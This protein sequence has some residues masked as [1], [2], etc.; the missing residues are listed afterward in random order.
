MS[1]NA[2][3]ASAGAPG[4]LAETG[5]RRPTVRER[6]Y[7]TCAAVHPEGKVPG[8]ASARLVEV[9]LAEGW[10]YREDGDG[11][12][13]EPPEALAFRGCTAWKVTLEGRWAALGLR[14]RHL[15]AG[16]GSGR[17]SLAHADAKTTALVKMHLLED[18]GGAL[19]PTVL[20][21]QL[22]RAFAGNAE[23][24]QP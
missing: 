19:R 17:L 21:D 18:I 24:G 23:T 1:S 22:V 12:R 7:L 2:S 10:I 4:P 13:L 6:Q 8:E 3:A 16:V 14:Q 20:G 15:I 5:G 11:F 9:M